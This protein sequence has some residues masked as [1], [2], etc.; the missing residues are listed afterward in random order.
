MTWAFQWDLLIAPGATVVID[1]DKIIQP[2]QAI[3]E[4]S[5]VALLALGLGAVAIRRRRGPRPDR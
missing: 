4:P 2:Y 1:I 5:G 3:P